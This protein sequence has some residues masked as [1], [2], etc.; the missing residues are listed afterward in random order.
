M[1]PEEILFIDALSRTTTGKM[2]RKLMTDFYLSKVQ[3]PKTS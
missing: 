1:V 3:T 2:D